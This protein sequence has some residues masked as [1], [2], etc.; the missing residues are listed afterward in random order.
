MELVIILALSVLNGLFALSET[1]VIAARKARLQQLVDK[2][3]QNASVALELAEQ[4]N[5][6]LSTVQIGITLIGQ[7]S[8]AFA[9]ATLAEDLARS[10]ENTPIAPYAAA[11]SFALIV[12]LTTYLSLIIGELVPKRLA[13]QSPE[14]I[15]S[16]VARPMRF[17]ETLTA[18]VVSLLSASTTLVL[19]LIGVRASE[20]PPVTEDEI[21]AMIQQGIDAGVFE[22]T[23]H[24]M[25]EGVFRLDMRR[26]TALMTPRTEVVWLDINDTDEEN[27]RKIMSNHH[28]R[29]PVCD[30][31]LDHVLG[32]MQTKDMLGRLFSGQPF[33]LRAV[34]KEPIFVPESMSA[35]KLL[36]LFR[37]T[38]RH[39]ALVIGE[40]G[41]LEGIITIQDILA[42]IV[43]TD[44]EPES[45]QRD[46]GSW[47]VDGM[48]PIDD[49]RELID[50]EEIPGEHD[51][52][53]TLAGFILHKLGSIP[54][55]GDSFEWDNFKFEVIDM[56]GNRI[57]KVVVLP[58]PTSDADAA[59]D[60]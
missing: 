7:V 29:F 37:S 9:G 13:L 46:D 44:D 4:P 19:R 28:S 36:E 15:A 40:Y 14:R 32:I 16:L 23:E 51:D 59:D 30:G 54:K 11:V 21:K 20:E 58:L 45:I 10:F 18:P 8:G 49:F 25:V 50:V 42:D 33:D 60:K 52:F 1:A 31:D 27:Q 47:L 17:L 43:G 2:G 5:R 6:F 34:M 3:D 53:E 38:G 26:V 12:L 39:T 35:A 56:D 24:D 48:M 57:D 41:G 55:A 22:E